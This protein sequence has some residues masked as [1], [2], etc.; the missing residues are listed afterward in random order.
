[1]ISVSRSRKD[2]SSET[3]NNSNTPETPTDEMP[4]ASRKRTLRPLTELNYTRQPSLQ[5]PPSSLMKYS[6]PK[7]QKFQLSQT[8]RQAKAAKKNPYATN[9]KELALK[10]QK[11]NSENIKLRLQNRDLQ[12]QLRLEQTLRKSSR[13]ST[14]SRS[15]VK[16]SQPSDQDG[17]EPGKKLKEKDSEI[18]DLQSIIAEKELTI[19]NLQTASKDAMH[20]R[21]RHTIETIKETFQ[22]EILSSV[23]HTHSKTI[24][25]CD[26]ASERINEVHDQINKLKACKN[27]RKPSELMKIIEERDRVKSLC[28]EELKTVSAEKLR[29][30]KE[31]EHAENRIEVAGISEVLHFFAEIRHNYAISEGTQKRKRRT[32]PIGV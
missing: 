3:K 23:A 20:Q 14:S 8:K 28:E 12:S 5:P 1:M 31:L 25:A 7:R 17:K 15:T 13:N 2:G 24:K 11:L 19:Q 6:P 4:E 10:A 18:Q 21:S 22:R 32:I 26:I 29:L 9:N 30:E 27:L 16:K